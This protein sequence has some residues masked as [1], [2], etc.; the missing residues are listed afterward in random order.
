MKR[1]ILAILVL[2]S[3][4]CVVN[5][6]QDS[7]SS[8]PSVSIP[9]EAPRQLVTNR[10]QLVPSSF[11]VPPNEYHSTQFNV[12]GSGRVVGSFR[13]DTNIMVY[14][15]DEEGFQNLSSGNQ[16]R[17]YYSSGKI[18]AGQIN[19]NLSGGSYYIVFANMYSVISTKHIT[20]N[21]NL[22]N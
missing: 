20:A 1:S 21:I 15:V 19:V 17:G 16:F 14:I 5:H 18:G 8:Q 11:T 2:L 9:N 13:S 4:G 12:S 7:S 6:P 3:S 10:Y 22:E